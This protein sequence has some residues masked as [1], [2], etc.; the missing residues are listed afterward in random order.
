MILMKDFNIESYKKIFKYRINFNF[1]Y[2]CIE[3][4]MCK[5]VKS[6]K[7]IRKNLK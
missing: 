4:I 7:F 5:I 3:I 2:I 1:N 6:Q